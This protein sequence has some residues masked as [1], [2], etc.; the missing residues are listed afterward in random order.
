MRS[1][2]QRVHISPIGRETLFVSYRA[3]QRLRPTRGHRMPRR[4]GANA[5]QLSS[6]D[7]EDGSGRQ[8][9]RLETPTISMLY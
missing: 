5:A 2:A 6:R 3:N 7:W 9:V 4:Q 1:M 8:G